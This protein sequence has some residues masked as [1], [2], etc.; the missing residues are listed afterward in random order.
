MAK[1]TKDLQEVSEDLEIC[2]MLSETE[3][4]MKK[5]GFWAQG[6]LNP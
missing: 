2:S 1:E 3:N 6:H 4:V 5:I